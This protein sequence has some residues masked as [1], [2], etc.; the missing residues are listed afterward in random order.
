MREVVEWACAA[1]LL[2]PPSDRR[3]NRYV[4]GVD[5]SV[6]PAGGAVVA[7]F[8]TDWGVLRGDPVEQQRSPG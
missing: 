8:V 4:V 3:A 5:A 6:A 1:V 7:E 2:E